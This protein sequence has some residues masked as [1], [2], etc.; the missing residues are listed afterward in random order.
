[1][2]SLV[3]IAR[4]EWE[5]GHR[6]FGELSA[7]PA[8]REALR[9]ELE[10]VTDE[11]R[12]RVGQTFTLAELAAVYDEAESWARPAVAERAVVRGWARDLS[13]V[14]DSAFH[15]YARGATDYAP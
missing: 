6:R 11:L 3:P 12:K 2:P 8:R 4:Q 9:A 10:V 7:D 1:V 5:S 13:T 14:V 15:L